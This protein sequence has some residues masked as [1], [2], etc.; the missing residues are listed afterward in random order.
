MDLRKIKAFVSIVSE[1]SVSSSISSIRSVAWVQSAVVPDVM[2]TFT[3]MW[4]LVLS[5]MYTDLRVEA[6]TI[7][8]FCCFKRARDQLENPGLELVLKSHLQDD[9]KQIP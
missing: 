8:G 1:I 3:A 2:I 5:P 9:S 6:N 4:T 7:Q